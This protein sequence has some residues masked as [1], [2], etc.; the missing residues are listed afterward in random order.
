VDGHAD[1]SLSARSSILATLGGISILTGWSIREKLEP[2][3]GVVW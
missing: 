3:N 1:L 2:V